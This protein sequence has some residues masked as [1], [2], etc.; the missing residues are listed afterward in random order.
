MEGWRCGDEGIVET[1]TNIIGSV[2]LS[3]LYN[4]KASPIPYSFYTITINPVHSSFHHKA[5]TGKQGNK[6]TQTTAE[7]ESTGEGGDS[8][9]RH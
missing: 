2:H 1:I 6:P 8:I 5:Q 7:K 3:R 4:R 9:Q